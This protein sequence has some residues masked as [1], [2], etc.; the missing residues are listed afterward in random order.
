MSDIVLETKVHRLERPWVNEL[1]V[2]CGCVAAIHDRHLASST[3]VRTLFLT[4]SACSGL[5]TNYYFEGLGWHRKLGPAE[6]RASHNTHKS[7]Y[8]H[9]PDA[10]SAYHT[11][12]TYAL[13]LTRCGMQ[14]MHQ[15]Q[16][17]VHVLI[18]SAVGCSVFC[19]SVLRV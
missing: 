10:S 16:G 15:A 14:M 2:E 19:W 12:L 11:W 17:H 8:D 9:A 13:K 1:Y 4:F 6:H 18:A 5:V 3:Q 7:A